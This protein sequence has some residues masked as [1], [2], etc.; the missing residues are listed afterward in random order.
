M[1]VVTEIEITVDF[2]DGVLKVIR[3]ACVIGGLDVSVSGSRLTNFTVE[4]R[5]E[6]YLPWL[7]NV[8][9]RRTRF[10]RLS[11]TECDCDLDLCEFLSKVCKWT[12][13]IEAE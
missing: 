12:V 5:I 1:S 4:E 2:R 10:V 11:K 9:Q 6:T 13:K 3:Y 8:E 7:S